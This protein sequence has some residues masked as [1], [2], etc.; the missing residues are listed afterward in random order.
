[1]TATVLDAKPQIENI[2]TG[3]TNK[4]RKIVVDGLAEILASTLI[5]QMKRQVFHWNVVG[6]LFY[7]LHQILRALRHS[8]V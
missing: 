2:A 5:L 1:M 8:H 3:L 4:V 6:P 7:S